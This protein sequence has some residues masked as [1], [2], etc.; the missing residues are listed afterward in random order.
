MEEAD[1]DFPLGERRRIIERFA[2]LSSGKNPPFDPENRAFLV[3][4]HL[5]SPE[6]VGLCQLGW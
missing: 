5:L 3:E 2:A 6:L 1:K 4:T